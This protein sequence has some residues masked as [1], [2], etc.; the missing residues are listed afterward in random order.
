MDILNKMS[1]MINEYDWTKDIENILFELLVHEQKK[2]TKP[3]QW[4]KLDKVY[5]GI[6]DGKNLSEMLKE[7]V[8]EAMLESNPHTEIKKGYVRI[9]NNN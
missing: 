7:G 8:I 3:C 9:A 4:F 6:V 5:T 2:H 1:F